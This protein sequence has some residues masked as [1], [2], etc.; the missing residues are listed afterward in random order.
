MKILFD[1]CA[2]DNQRFGGVPKYYVNLFKNFSKNN[3]IELSIKY[4]NN[5]DLHK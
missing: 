3:N 5:Y 4:S 1:H 2:F